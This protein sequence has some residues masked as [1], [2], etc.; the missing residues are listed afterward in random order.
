MYALIVILPIKIR[1][2]HRD[3]SSGAEETKVA[4]LKSQSMQLKDKLQNVI[5]VVEN[6]RC[7]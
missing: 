6:I 2:L 4:I 5:D 7:R 1:Q 3:A